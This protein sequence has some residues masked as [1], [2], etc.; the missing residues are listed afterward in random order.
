MSMKKWLLPVLVIVLI[1]A[2]VVAQHRLRG[3]DQP[4]QQLNCPNLQA[5]CSTLLDKVPVTVGITGELKV[6]QPFTVWL[7][8]E[9]AGKVQASF[10]M[11]GMD[12]GFNLY[13]LRRDPDGVFR[14]RVT[15]PVCVSGRRDWVMTLEIDGERLTVPFV[16][17]L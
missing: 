7:K 13:T 14:G 17:D 10:T 1:A 2:V 4:A 12:M 11:E 5:G 6:L 9:A 16:T 3:A 8:A 15:L